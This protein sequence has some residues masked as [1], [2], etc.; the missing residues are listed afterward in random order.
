MKGKAVGGVIHQPYYN[1]KLTKKCDE[2]GRTMWGIVGVGVGG[3]DVHPPPNNKFLI[4]TTKS[5]SDSVVE[6]A[7]CAFSP[8]EI[9]R[10]G[11]AGHKVNT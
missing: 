2:L 5:H 10:V 7:L 8:D 6:T 3:I 9:L 11:G 4:T 1:Y